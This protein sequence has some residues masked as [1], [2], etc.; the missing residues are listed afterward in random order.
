MED[1][2][3]SIRRIIADD[4]EAMSAP[5]PNGVA[6]S[7][8]KNVVDLTE[9][10]M[11]PASHSEPLLRVDLEWAQEEPLEDNGFSLEAP[12]ELV[13]GYE[14]E[15]TASPGSTTVIEATS[16]SAE[17]SGE[18]SLLSDQA[19]A[20]ISSAFE[21]LGAAVLPNRPQTIEDLMKE[22]LRP[23]LKGW[24]DDNLPSIVERLVQAEI[25]RVTRG[26]A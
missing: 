18:T 3:A 26:R 16:A 5:E 14:V 20:S 23:M 15:P 25:E 6:S 4:Q 17:A 11:M 19:S 8:H 7:P 10:H 22:M 12:S 1:I 13:R 21:R 24:L 9:R 2:L